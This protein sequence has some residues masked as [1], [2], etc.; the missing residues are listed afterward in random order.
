MSGRPA[1]VSTALGV[2]LWCTY[3]CGLCVMTAM[4]SV[5]LVDVNCNTPMVARKARPAS[6]AHGPLV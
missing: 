6:Q 3:T 2:D 5:A 4:V 1:A